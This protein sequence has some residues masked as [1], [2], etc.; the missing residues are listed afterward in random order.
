MPPKKNPETPEQQSKRFKEEAEKLVKD[1][2]LDPAR[3]DEA[4][5]RLV[6][7]ALDSPKQ[8]H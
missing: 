5:D 4:M 1:G 6:R 8:N 3:A 7:K 2:D